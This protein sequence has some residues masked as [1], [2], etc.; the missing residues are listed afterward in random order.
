MTC[1]NTTRSGTLRRWHPHGCAGSNIGGSPPLASFNNAWNST[2]IGSSRH[3][4]TAGTEHLEDHGLSQDRD[5]HIPCLQSV[6]SQP[7]PL[8]CRSLLYVSLHAY[9]VL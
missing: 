7:T 9:C 3:D 5:H 6:T 2:Q 1:S 4:G 8:I